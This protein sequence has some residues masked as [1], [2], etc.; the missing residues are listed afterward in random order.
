MSKFIKFPFALKYKRTAN[1]WSPGGDWYEISTW[2]NE[3]FGQHQWDYMDE[4]FMFRT[5][6]DAHWFVLRWAS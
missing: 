1:W 6:K 5:E 3:T 2:M 4:Y